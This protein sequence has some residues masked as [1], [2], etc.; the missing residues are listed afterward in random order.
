MSS[1]VIIVGA[2]LAGLCCA[3]QLH[4][5]GVPF[6][7][8]D[9]GDRV[10]GRIRTDLVDGFRLDRGFQVFLSSYPEAREVLDYNDLDLRPFLPGA[11]VRFGGRFHTL[12]DPWRR[13]I[14]AVG[15]VFSPIGSLR[16]KLRVG[17]IRSQSVRGD[18]ASLVTN[19]ETTTLEALQEAGF[20]PAMID[21]FFK[22]F[23]GGIFLDAD[24]QTSSRLFFYLFRMFAQG[25]ACLPSQGMEAIPQQIA[26]ELPASFLQ[27]SCKVTRIQPDAVSLADGQQMAARAVVV[28]TD[29]PHAADLLGESIPRQGQGVTCLYFAASRPPVSQ[30]ILVLNGESGPINNLCVP[31]SV[32]PTYG[33]KDQ[34]LIS[35][36]V[37]GASHDEPQ[38]QQQVRDQLQDW[39]GPDVRTWRHLRNYVIPYALPRQV[40]PALAEFE[41]PVRW[42]PGIYLCG[43]HRDQGSIQGA[44]VSGR[45]A[46]DAILQDWS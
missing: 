46:A 36:T 3:R 25:D 26:D 13:P 35:V 24:L 39:F 23:L 31:T 21:R 44:M 38:L 20:S 45:R 43:D 12:A 15:S 41:R 7:L 5:R 8:L 16:D 1:P 34:S 33:P 11:L 30:P 40:P 18:L 2:G 17:R 32:S 10:G 14:A 19:R 37:L 29:A 9:S 28:A 27:L 42:K 22:P 4:R 6:R